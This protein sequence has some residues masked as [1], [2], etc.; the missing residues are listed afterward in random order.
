MCVPKIQNCLLVK[1]RR[2]YAAREELK[3]SKGRL[4]KT[5]VDPYLPNKIVPPEYIKDVL[6]EA[7]RDFPLVEFEYQ[8]PH[9]FPLE[10]YK[11]RYEE[12]E[13]Q[14]L[15]ILNWRF[16]WFGKPEPQEKK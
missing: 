8:I 11:N 10:E 5:I 15:E 2:L 7:N 16:Q 6:D 14:M 12:L 1:S 13:H 9:N 4:E 3:M